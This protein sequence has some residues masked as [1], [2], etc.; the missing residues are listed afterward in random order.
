MWNAA[1][2]QCCSAA[3]DRE[4]EEGGR[5]GTV[6]LLRLPQFLFNCLLI[7]LIMGATRTSGQAASILSLKQF[8]ALKSLLLDNPPSLLDLHQERPNHRAAPSS[9]AS[10][11]RSSEMSQL[12]EATL[13]QGGRGTRPRTQRVCKRTETGETSPGGLNPQ[14][15]TN[16]SMGHVT[17][18]W[19]GTNLQHFPPLHTDE[20]LLFKL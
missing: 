4:G 13:P 11:S 17:A 15:R 1:S 6:L 19:I 20:A 16:A 14:I 10:P 18:Y 12:T 7:Y 8:A 9:S 5:Q 2:L 3:S